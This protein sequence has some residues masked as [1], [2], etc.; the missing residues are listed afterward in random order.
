MK[1]FYS[2]KFRPSNPAKY[3]GD[4]SA[5]KYRS[6][7]ERQVFRWCD[8]HS[9]VK[10]WSSEEVVIPYRCKT[11]GKPHRYFTD[12]KITFANGETYIIEIKPK[13]QTEPPKKSSRKTQRYI[14]EVMT[15]AKNISK[16]EAA[17]LWCD[18]RG[19]KFDIW[20]EE[21]IKGMGIKLLT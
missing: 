13:K 19:Y 7:W 21:T 5:I 17:K 18:A 20:T 9:S 6:L 14:K 12:L 10:T 16:W 15:Y 8:T 2:G 1:S 3:K 11:D 4:I